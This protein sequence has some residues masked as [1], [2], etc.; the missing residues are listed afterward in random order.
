MIDLLQRQKPLIRIEP[1]L[2]GKSM[3]SG[4]SRGYCFRGQ[5]TISDI[6]SMLRD[7]AAARGDKVPFY[8][9]TADCMTRPNGT[10]ESWQIV[11][12]PVAYRGEFVRGVGCTAEEAWASFQGQTET[13]A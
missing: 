10:T 11:Y 2:L 9:V 5:M 4:P 3:T 7:H 1:V 8:R 6:N 13:L 12:Y